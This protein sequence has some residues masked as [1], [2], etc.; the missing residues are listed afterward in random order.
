MLL[1]GFAG[2]ALRLLLLLFALR[3][4]GVA[5]DEVLTDL[6]HSPV[7]LFALRRPP[8]RGWISDGM[9]PAA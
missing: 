2:C 7:T 4:L 5:D 9:L 8:P 1:R 3:R 6:V